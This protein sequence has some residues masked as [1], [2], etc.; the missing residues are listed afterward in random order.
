MNII[1]IINIII[2]MIV[3][4]I[5]RCTFSTA[6]VGTARRP[7]RARGRVL[8]QVFALELLRLSM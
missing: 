3:I 4:I 1:V 2:F 7:A 5:M 8:A 6:P